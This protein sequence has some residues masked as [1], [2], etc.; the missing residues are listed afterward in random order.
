MGEERHERDERERDPV[1]REQPQGARERV[2]PQRRRRRARLARGH[3][4]PGDQEARE[5]EEDRDA[6]VEALEELPAGERRVRTAGH[7]DV[8]DGYEERRDPAQAVE[9]G[10]ARRDPRLLPHRPPLH[11]GDRGHPST[12]STRLDRSAGAYGDGSGARTPVC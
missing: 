6:D 3:P 11:S 7:R 2:V 12:S 4:R 1:G 8:V 9:P 5:H 10:E